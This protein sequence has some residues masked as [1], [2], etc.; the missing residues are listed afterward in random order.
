MHEIRD[1]LSN[2]V[3][4]DFTFKDAYKKAEQ[5]IAQA[6]SANKNFCVKILRIPMFQGPVMLLTSHQIQP[7]EIPLK[8]LKENKFILKQMNKLIRKN[9]NL[10]F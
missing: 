2:Y 1:Q 6:C 5:A 9:Q 7:L 3:P 10:F 4:V 8:P